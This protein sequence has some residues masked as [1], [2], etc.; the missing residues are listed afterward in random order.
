[1]TTKTDIVNQALILLGV[2]G[3]TDITD[4]TTNAKRANI[5]YEQTQKQV[6]RE[7]PHTC[8]VRT[9]TLGAQ[10][11]RADAV[12]NDK[13]TISYHLPE[14]C[15]RVIKV[16]KDFDL[17]ERYIFTDEPEPTITYVYHNKN[18]ESYSAGLIESLVYMLAYKLSMAITGTASADMYTLYKNTI[19]NEKS[20]DSQ[21]IL[22]QQF[23]DDGDFDFKA[24]SYF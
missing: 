9:L 23:F 8:A 1:M 13:Y 19:A 4:K 17:Q 6:L 16:N 22:T 10:Q 3:I 18:E 5:L 7:Y 20:V 21:Q 24:R 12:F 11:I 2:E 14:D 15:L